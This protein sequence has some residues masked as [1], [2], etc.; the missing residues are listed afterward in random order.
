MTQPLLNNPVSHLKQSYS[1]F[2]NFLSEDIYETIST[3]GDS[4]RIK[5]PNEKNAPINK[6]PVDE[7]SDK[8]P[9]KKIEDQMVN[10][11]FRKIQLQ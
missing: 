3:T 9:D 4:I 7:I 6:T 2:Y 8:S 10:P 1:I 5:A 11:Y